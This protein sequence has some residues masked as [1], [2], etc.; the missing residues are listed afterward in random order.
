MHRHFYEVAILA[1][2]VGDWRHT[3]YCSCYEEN[4][5]SLT[6]STVDRGQL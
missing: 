3:A 5:C 6:L 1:L 4:G 2:A